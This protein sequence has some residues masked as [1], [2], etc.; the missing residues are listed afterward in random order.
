MIYILFV[1][2]L[3]LAA[4]KKPVNEVCSQFEENLTVRENKPTIIGEED[5]RQH[6]DKQDAIS[7]L[8]TI[9]DSFLIRNMSDEPN[10]I[11]S[12]S[13]MFNL[14]SYETTKRQIGW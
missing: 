2:F 3:S 13:I 5:H 11:M 9:N 14:D 6:E 10:A 12:C 4:H 1:D 8:T 7:L